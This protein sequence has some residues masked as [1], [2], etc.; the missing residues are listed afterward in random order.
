LKSGIVLVGSLQLA[1]LSG[2]NRDEIHAY[3]VPKEAEVPA[4]AATNPAQQTATATQVTW[5][6]PQ[7]WQEVETTSTMRIATFKASNGLEVAVTAFPGDVG[8]LVAN[9]NRWRGQVGLD[10]TDEQG[11]EDSI[12]RNNGVDV[13]VVDVLGSGKRLIGTIIDVHDGKTWFVKLLGATDQLEEVKEDLVQFSTSFHIHNHNTDHTLSSS[14][15][16]STTQSNLQ[17]PT[18]IKRA[19]DWV[20]PAEWAAEENSSSI[21]MEAYTSQSGGRITLTALI[22][23]GGGMLGNINR[24]RAQLGLPIVGSVSEINLKDLGEGAVFV[25]FTSPDES[26]RMAAGIMPVGNQTLFFKLT[27]TVSAVEAELARFETFIQA[28][29]IGRQG[30]P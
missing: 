12:V 9:V 7:G 28:Y 2:C 25:D 13:I 19:S 10:P 14:G 27:G 29:E 22:G 15:S 23:P 11:I 5:E 30:Q 20:Q 16:E 18:T 1:V 26:G 24:W 17:S 3:R 8:G 4:A 21:L 6:V